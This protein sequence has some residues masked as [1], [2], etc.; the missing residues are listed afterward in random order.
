MRTFVRTV[1]KTVKTLVT[2]VG[3]R[4]VS[5]DVVV[6]TAGKQIL[7]AV[8]LLSQVLRSSPTHLMG[9]MCSHRTWALAPAYQGRALRP[10]SRWCWSRPP[11][12]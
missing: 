12:A 7:C 6:R 8:N 10:E 5:K 11:Q 3:K 4:Y 9:C 2:F 1:K